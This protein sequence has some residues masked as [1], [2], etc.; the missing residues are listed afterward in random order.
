MAQ[1]R[2]KSALSSVKLITQDTLP[3]YAYRHIVNECLYFPHFIAY[4]HWCSLFAEL[5][6]SIA[7][8]N[9]HFTDRLLSSSSFWRITG[10]AIALIRPIMIRPKLT[11]VTAQSARQTAFF[12]SLSLVAL[13]KYYSM[14]LCYLCDYKP[15]IGNF[16][17]ESVVTISARSR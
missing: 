9:A 4:L 17:S 13:F 11:K 14:C 15:S 16:L 2:E 12:H 8:S 7:L 1:I 5:H 3:I 10:K 6:W